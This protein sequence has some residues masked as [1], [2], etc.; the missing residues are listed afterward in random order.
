MI[1]PEIIREIDNPKCYICTEDNIPLYKIC[2]CADSFLCMDCLILTEEKINLRTDNNENKFKCHICRQ[3]LNLEY[4]PNILYFKKL[5]MHLGIRVFFILVD[6]IPVFVLHNFLKTKYPTLFFSSS[7]NF[8]YFS[9]L[10]I[11]FF[12]NTTRFLLTTLYKIN[13]SRITFFYGIDILFSIITLCL[14]AF[15]FVK[16]S[17]E[18]VDIYTCLILIFNYQLCFLIVW[19]MFVL[20]KFGKL[21]LELKYRYQN[22]RILIQNVYFPIMIDNSN[23]L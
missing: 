13:D 2:T 12:R 20:D 22:Y 18:E 11:L 6:L 5:F 1:Q 21:I 7:D 15:C 10:N 23:Q 4:A 8:L 3:N 9:I 14:F 16:S 19:L 17:Y